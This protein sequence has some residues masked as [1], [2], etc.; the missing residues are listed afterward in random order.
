MICHPE[1]VP[2]CRDESKACPERR[3]SAAADG[4]SRMGTCIL[5][6]HLSTKTGAPH[7]VS[8]MW[9]STNFNPQALYQGAAFRRAVNN[10]K[11]AGL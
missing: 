11:R 10:A 1:R 3:S 8:E 7:L 5:Q 9:E 6:C 4:R 2:A